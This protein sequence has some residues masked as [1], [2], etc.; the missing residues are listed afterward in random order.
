MENNTVEKIK[1][2]IAELPQDVQDAILANDFDERIAKI[3]QANRLHIDQIGSLGD[4][5]MLIMLG[6]ASSEGFTERLQKNLHLYDEQATTITQAVNNEIFLPIRESM[7]KIHSQEAKKEAPPVATPAPVVVAEPTVAP[8]VAAAPTPAAK[9]DAADMM[10][11]QKTVSIP[12]QKPD[13]PV[14]PTPAAPTI[15]NS[16]KT[17]PYREP[18]E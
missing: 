13:T 8:I 4:E 15:S 14:T 12:A 1:A 16:Y 3:G 5:T 2:R 9:M 11:S 17:D 6:F 7:K 10:L 18:A